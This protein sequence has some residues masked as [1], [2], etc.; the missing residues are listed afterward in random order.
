MKTKLKRTLI[1]AMDEW[2]ANEADHEDRP[3]KVALQP[4]DRRISR[5]DSE[6]LDWLQSTET[7]IGY[8]VECCAWGVDFEAPYAKTIREAIDLAM[9]AQ[10]AAASSIGGDKI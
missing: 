3:E 9:D 7:S 1:E 4:V 6:R 8:N 10:R 5:G 2:T